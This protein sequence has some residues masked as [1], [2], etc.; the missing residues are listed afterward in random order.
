MLFSSELTIFS[1]VLD[2]LVHS[3]PEYDISALLRNPPA[4]FGDLYPNVKVIKGDYDSADILTEAASQADIVVRKLIP[5]AKPRK[6]QP[7]E[8][9]CHIHACHIPSSHDAETSGPEG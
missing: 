1:T 8:S 9:N 6:T 3:H 4:T 2:T 5:A 7:R